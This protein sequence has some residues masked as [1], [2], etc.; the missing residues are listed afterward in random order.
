MR[1]KNYI[2]ENCLMIGVWFILFL[3]IWTQ[4]VVQTES[5]LESTLFSLL[6]L[7]TAYPFSRYLSKNLL[8]KAMKRKN[9]TIFI[10]QF[11]ALSILIGAIFGLLILLFAYLE[12]VR[13]FPSSAYFDLD[14]PVVMMFVPISAGV[15]INICICGVHFLSKIRNSKK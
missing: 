13:L 1:I 10:F 9:A 5:I 15:A 14:I 3:T 4:S 11:L 7:I 8:Q 12:Y 2:K 6:V